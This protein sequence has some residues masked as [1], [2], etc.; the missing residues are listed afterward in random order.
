MAEQ[1]LYSVLGVS[2]DAD[3]EAIKKAYRVLALKYHPDRNPGNK[4]AEESFKGVNHANEVLSDAKKRKLYDDFGEMGL[5]DGFN[6]DAYRQYQSGG[7]GGSQGGRGF[8]DIFGGGGAGGHV[9][10]SDLFAQHFPGGRAS[11]ASPFGR[12]R[13]VRGRDV[14]SEV[15]IDLPLA[16]RGGEVTLSVSG[17]SVRVRIPAG[18]KEGTRMRIAG[19]GGPAPGGQPGDLVLAVKVEAHPWFWIE[20]DDLHVRL[21]VALV[22]AWRGTR[23]TVPTPQGEVTLRV[24]PHTVHG[25]KL[26]LRGKGIPGS[27]RR[28]ASDLMVHIEI[29]PLPE[30]PATE[31]AMKVLETVQPTA[32]RDDLRF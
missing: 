14:E 3:S 28:E 16:V 10:F 11:G 18:A 17:E 6:A 30:T 24:P 32:A 2:R 27:A 5:R 7:G 15:T 21:P 13:A 9:D 4:K 22:E 29:A 19:K 23:V 25:A 31:E 12:G 8:E 26:R 1:D 20:D